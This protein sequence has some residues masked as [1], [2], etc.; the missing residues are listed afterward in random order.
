MI[1]KLTWRAALA[2][3]AMWAAFVARSAAD[4]AWLDIEGPSGETSLAYLAFVAVDGTTITSDG[5]NFTL[6]GDL[7]YRDRDLD[8]LMLTD[9]AFDDGVDAF[10]GLRI[11]GLPA[12]TYDVES[13]HYDG[14]GFPGQ[15]QVEFREEGNPGSTQMLTGGIPF[16]T[17]AVGYQVVSDGAT[18]YELLFREDDG[19]Q[20]SRLNGLRLRA[21]G[22]PVF[23][24]LTLFDAK[25]A[26]TR[27]AGGFPDPFFTNTSSDPDYTA[28]PLWWRRSGFGFD[29]AGN[30]EVFEKDAN[31]GVG[32]AAR[33]ETT[34]TGLTPGVI[35]GLYAAFLSV[36]SETWRVKAGLNASELTL[37][38]PLTPPGA[39]LDLGL[40]SVPNSNRH[41]YLGF[42]G[43]ATADGAG[44]LTV[45]VDDGDGTRS[46]ART[47]YEGIAVGQPFVVPGPP[48]LPAD[49]VDVAPDG[50]WTWFN[51]E[52]SIFHQGFLYVGYVRA[53]GHV[54]LTRFD[55]VT[56]TTS[57]MQ[58]STTRSQQT[59]DHNNPSLTALPDGRLLAVYSKHS[60]TAEFY[61][62]ISL[63]TSPATDGDWDTEQIK[64]T[65]RGNTYANTYLLPGESNTVYN[66]HRS[67]NFNPTLTR[68]YNLGATWDDP[69]HFIKTGTGSARPYPRYVSD[70]TNRIDLIYTDGHPR[71]EDNSIYHLYYQG[72]AF[73]QSD[74]TE[75]R[76]LADLPIEHDLG[77]R[78]TV[79]YAYSGAAWG[80]GE[81]PDDWVPSGRAWTWDIHYGQDGHP[82]CAFQVQRDDVTGTGWN[83]DRI[84]Y[85]Y[86]RWDGSEW[87]R[88]FIA[89]AGRG[90]YSSEDDYGGGMSIDPEDPRVV[91]CSSNA[92]D[93]FSLDSID[94]VPLN[95][96]DR[97]EIYRGVTLDG[98]LTFT[99]EAVT[100]S[101]S[102]D[103]LRPIVPEQH[104]YDRALVWFYGT[105]STY[106]S[107]QTRVLALLENPLWIAGAS[108]SHPE[109][110]VTWG[111]RVGAR[112]DIMAGTD[113]T[114]YTTPVATNIPSQGPVTTHA[115]T[116][117][118]SIVDAPSVLL[119]VEDRR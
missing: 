117:P 2:V 79:V 116:L 61:S 47:W 25:D 72:G 21:V 75:V 28:G 26:N 105:Y 104:G 83:H 81:G 31:G 118:A 94:E 23:P 32:D 20:R 113:P 42:I 108:V 55:P 107:Y 58:L 49:A 119:R 24:P 54:G 19:N 59:D 6:F 48:P 68:S 87:T 5:V 30:A 82:V 102:A 1:H 64:T 69:T 7:D 71:N 14:G 95:P 18:T 46:S 110:Q 76:A 114:A 66:F 22:D 62:R 10:V 9:F 41:Q 56:A 40:S 73:R 93:P 3:F 70:H 74:G 45:V 34:L 12:G 78:G 53:D 86:A 99:W 50:A 37:F 109:V 36:P 100:E 16:S 92:A 65:P 77:E 115:I 106:T 52:R 80:P 97:Y 60:S 8:D 91:Y 38:H 103:N 96:N 67:I 101:S 43:N 112:Y 13:W 51:D 90:L 111:S 88:R 11:A 89:Q 63:A 17:N 15:I 39:I 4:I 84:Y 29:I 98:G 35:Y 57:H 44:E 27:A 33:L 85:Y